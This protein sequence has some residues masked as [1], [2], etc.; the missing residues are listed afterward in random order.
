MSS[1]PV[2]ENRYYMKLNNS[3]KIR[4]NWAKNGPYCPYTFKTFARK[5]GII[6]LQKWNELAK[7]HQV[8]TVKMDIHLDVEIVKIKG[9]YRHYFYIKVNF[10]PHFFNSVSLCEF[11]DIILFSTLRCIVMYSN[12]PPRKFV[13][14]LLP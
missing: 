7:Q 1:I 12:P 3:W 9:H 8:E 13:C 11:I 4:K 10:Q 6:C 2:Q 5:A 14:L